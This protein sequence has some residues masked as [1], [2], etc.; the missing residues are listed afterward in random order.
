MDAK[1]VDFAI[2][3]FFIFLISLSCRSK[4]DKINEFVRSCNNTSINLK[5]SYVQSMKA[6]KVSEN[7]IAFKVSM[8]IESNA[9][10]SEMHSAIFPDLMR[11]LVF[12]IKLAKELID[13]GVTFNCV[14]IADDESIIVRQIFNKKYFSEKNIKADGLLGEDEQIDV[15]KMV[16]MIN[17]G[18]PVIDSINDITIS[19]LELIGDNNAQ[20][21]YLVDEETMG[22]FMENDELGEL[23]K[24]EYLKDPKRV[25]AIKQFFAL[26]S[27]TFYLKYANEDMSKSKKIII[28]KEDL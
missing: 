7:E 3:M 6:E 9:L 8:N 14:L 15:S 2:T 28:T 17:K 22:Y 4:E 5:D 19:K 25:T 10:N 16:E 18:L 21:V 11:E 12:S 13:E 23:M 20:F 1:K 24:E 26:G 27:D